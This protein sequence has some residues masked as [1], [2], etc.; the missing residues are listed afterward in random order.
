MK[1]S[2]KLHLQ[3]SPI[4]EEWQSNLTQFKLPVLRIDNNREETRL[5]ACSAATKYL[6]SK[7]DSKLTVLFH[8]LVSIFLSPLHPPH[9]FT[10]LNHASHYHSPPFTHDTTLS[11]SPT[12]LNQESY[13][14]YSLCLANF[15]Q[16]AQ[17]FLHIA[18]SKAC[19]SR[20][21][22]LRRSICRFHSSSFPSS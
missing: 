18:F 10:M 19:Q 21:H 14:Y 17:I 9:L 20:S 12:P 11:H 15:L 6:I 8:D 13:F 16:D 7:K 22:P 1:E 4:K 3:L 5:H 2:R